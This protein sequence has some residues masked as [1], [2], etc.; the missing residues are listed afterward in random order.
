MANVLT[1]E[2]VK[3][4][5]NAL[6][7]HE[8]SALSTADV[9]ALLHA[10]SCF[11]D[12]IIRTLWQ[13]FALSQSTLCLMAVGG[14][15]REEMFPHSDLDLLLLSE[16]ALCEPETA[17]WQSFT[18]FLWDCG[19]H[20]GQ[21]VRTLSECEQDGQRDL[22]IATTFFEARLLCGNVQLAQ[23]LKAITE[24]PTFWPL[25]E[26]YHG[27]MAEREQRY[28]RYHN[29][30]YNLE[31][32]VKY[33]PGGLRDLHLL[34]WLT[35]RHNGD[36][37]LEQMRQSSFIYPEEFELLFRAQQF[38]FKVR[39]ALHLL[40]KRADNRLL[41]AHQVRVSELLGFEQSQ[42]N[43][44]VETMMRQYFRHTHHVMALSEMLLQDYA[45]QFLHPAEHETG[46]ALDDDFFLQGNAI[47]IGDNV[48]FS[49]RPE[50][51]ITLFIHLAGAPARYI[52]ASTL[53]QL[54]RA[55]SRRRHYLIEHEA[56]R[57]A[58]I[59][60]LN[61]PKAI[62]R[63][64]VPM[65]QFGVLNA[66]FSAWDKIDG[67][68]QFDLFHA[69]TVDE[70]TLRVLLKIENFLSAPAQTAHP[71]CA[72][73]FPQ[74]PNRTLLY[75]TALFHDIAKG[76]GGD[77]AELGAID[78]YEFAKQHFFGE[79][80]AETM[81]WLVQNHLV[82]SI[83]AQRRDIYDPDIINQFARRV[84][85][86]VR[87][88]YLLC[89]T[90]ADISATNN[91]LWNSWKRS[92]L[93]TLYQ[94]TTQQLTQG[95]DAP[96]DISEQILTHRLQAL[97]ALRDDIQ[98]QCLDKAQVQAFWARCP[99]DYFL[100][101]NGA[102]LAWHLRL[103]TPNTELVCKASN[104]FSRG[105]SELF[106]YCPDQPYVFNKIARTLEAKKVSIHDAQIITSHDGYCLDSFIFTE[107]NGELVKFD[108]RREIESA[109][110]AALLGE[111]QPATPRQNTR[112]DHF[113]ITTQVRF[114]NRDKRDQTELEIFTLD[115][116]GLLAQISAIFSELN[117]SLINAKIMTIG[118]K[119]ED[120]FILQNADGEALTPA[121]C[122]QLET[123]LYHALD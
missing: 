21:A 107:H 14:Y 17:R 27:R 113:A 19:L 96:L 70:H 80:E 85:S 32:D 48:T 84:K 49:E 46:K 60:L 89:L 23:A 61:Q 73:I 67:L 69:Y 62:A 82:M 53:R 112:L 71:L 54:R 93:Q 41:F 12:H 95:S 5:L 92:L 13:Q 25:A 40:L 65:R 9:T 28:A 45:E 114:L 123:A 16:T 79:S 110:E 30:S 57:R 31:P 47:R 115:K 50:R 105:G 22:S 26:Y 55:L 29:T 108:R 56:V 51:I 58:F 119:A 120:F 118:E 20:L 86:Q 116:P 66:Y 94:F 2:G 87:L 33:S 75:I 63:A 15:G 1:V 34:S 103:I 37:S 64:L 121:Q 106:V 81:A 83:T 18:Q 4:A 43:R 98:A 59:T 42:S 101:N 11:F 8:I 38:L 88:D 36:Q 90:V 72:A 102:Q 78:V 100:R 97:D 77:H 3:A 76:R 7:A 111:Y 109:V 91:Q 117:L 24:Q 74:L 10:R 52:H 104:R 122:E 44:A 39:F 99:Q 68:M 35:R 6:K